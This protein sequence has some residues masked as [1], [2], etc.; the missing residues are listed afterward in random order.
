MSALASM[1]RLVTIGETMAVFIHDP[2]G[3]AHSYRLTAA[4]AESN[5][6]IAAARLG[7]PARWL[8]R[9]GEDELGTFVRDFVADHGVDV[10]VDW[11][12]S[13]PTAACVKEVRPFNTRMRYYRNTSAARRLDLLDLALVEDTD[14]LHLTGVTAALSPE[15]RQLL[16]TLLRR[17][18]G[19]GRTSFDVN[20][21]AQL[22]SGPTEAAACLLP[23]AEAADLVFIGDDEARSLLGT[24]DPAEV[25]AAL[26]R[27]AGDEVVLKAGG[28]A[29]LLLA[30]DGVVAAEPA[31]TVEV[32]DLTGAGD[33]FA[34]GYLVAR[35]W[36][37]S[38][39][40][41]LRLG[42]LVASRAIGV[43]GDIGP[44]VDDAEL[45]ELARTTE[46]SL[47]ETIGGRA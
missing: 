24:D 41:R 43:A 35:S 8:S 36:G 42:H 9:L 12:P 5:V 47:P 15:D 29:A 34:A 28:G 45:V 20:Y 1:N 19:L 10:V 22:W 17:R 21:R 25:A 3:P 30:T 13:R 38:V 6:A 26:V 14:H 18:R 31:R 44:D 4:G 27:K 46:E 37:W 32:V 23:L 2:A 7:L 16:E 40:G 33:A 39:R 11:D